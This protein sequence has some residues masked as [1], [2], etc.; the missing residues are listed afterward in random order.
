MNKTKQ[1][2]TKQ[3]TDYTCFLFP[4]VRGRR[5]CLLGYKVD[6][7]QKPVCEVL[8]RSRSKWKQKGF[9][10]A[11]LKKIVISTANYLRANTTH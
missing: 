1:N 10:N 8:L 9:F 6:G 3:N 4:G 5:V 11:V 2:K 7:G